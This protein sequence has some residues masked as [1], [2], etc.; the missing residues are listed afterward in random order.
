[1]Q[2]FERFDGV[3]RLRTPNRSCFRGYG[4]RCP[5]R[6]GA[7]ASKGRLAMVLEGPAKP[8]VTSGFLKTTPLTL[9]QLRCKISH[10]FPHPWGTWWWRASS[11]Q[12][13]VPRWRLF[14]CWEV[15]RDPLQSKH[16][17]RSQNGPGGGCRISWSWYKRLLYNDT[18]YTPYRNIYKH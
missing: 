9:S 10:M 13:A 11:S 7:Q 4:R 18:M 8:L 6:S 12:P 17:Y 15:D 1:M 2:G 14:K 16:A 3:W 5:A